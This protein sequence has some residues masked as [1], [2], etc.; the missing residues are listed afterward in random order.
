MRARNCS[1]LARAMWA[2][3]NSGSAASARHLRPG[4]GR[5][6]QVDRGDVILDG[7]R[8]SA[9]HRQIKAVL[10]RHDVLQAADEFTV[11]VIPHYH[12]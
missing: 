4:P 1:S 2:S 8:G 3:A 10:Q 7:G 12:E 11:I 6:Q 9:G 5:Q